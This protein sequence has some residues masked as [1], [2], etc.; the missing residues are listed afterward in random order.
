MYAIAFDFDTDKLKT[1]YPG[2]SWQNAY[3]EVRKFLNAKGFDHQQG[4]VYYG[5]DK[6]TQV[7]TILTVVELSAQF[8]Y[9]KDSVSDIRVL[10]L[11]ANDDLVP[12]LITGSQISKT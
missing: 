12:A 3:G 1:N 2:P 8:P 9:L 6:V 7:S 10:Q 4:S 11:L 5:N